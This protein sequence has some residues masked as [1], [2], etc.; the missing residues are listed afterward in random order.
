MVLPDYQMSICLRRTLLTCE[1]DINFKAARFK[2]KHKV[3]NSFNAPEACF[4]G[5]L[6][7]SATAQSSSSNSAEL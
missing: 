2:E 5:T 1:N 4:H 3:Q 6:T 7:S